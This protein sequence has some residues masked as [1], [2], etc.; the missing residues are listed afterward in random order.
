MDEPKSLR[1]LRSREV[2]AKSGIPQASRYEMI[3]RGEFPKPINLGGPRIGW[4][5]HEIDAWIAERVRA[6]RGTP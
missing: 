1:V 4:L 2:T 6:S 5:E 3:A